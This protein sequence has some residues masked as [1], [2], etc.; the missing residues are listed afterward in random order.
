MSGRRARAIW[1]LRAAVLTLAGA[2][3]VHQG[4][5]LF[6][7][8]SHEHELA[9]V[10]MYLTWAAPASGVLLFLA[11]MQLAGRAGRAAGVPML[12]RMRTLWLVGAATLLLVFCAQE[13]LETLLSEGRVPHVGDLLGAGGWTAIPLAL[14]VGG[15]IALALRGAATVLRWAAARRRRPLVRRARAAPLAPAP[16]VLAAARS[17]L[18]RRLAGRGPPLHR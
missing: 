3:A 5:D 4:R 15:L 8:A 7:S 9:R 11:I 6:A 2:V 18:A 17:V 1:R 10:H 12:P 14:A 16:P 13:S